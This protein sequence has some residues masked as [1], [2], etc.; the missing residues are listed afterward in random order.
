MSRKRFTLEQAIA[1]LPAARRLARPWWPGRGGGGGRAGSY[2]VQSGKEAV[3][4]LNS[5]RLRSVVSPILQMVW[6]A[7][8]AGSGPSQ[9]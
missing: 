9:S 5:E 3:D 7:F 6:M 1:K 2:G 4:P 8:G